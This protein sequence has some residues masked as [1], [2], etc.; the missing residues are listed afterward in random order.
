MSQ[1]LETCHNNLN[2]SDPAVHRRLISVVL[3]RLLVGG[4]GSHHGNLREPVRG[5][6]KQSFNKP[7]AANSPRGEELCRA[8][9]SKE[10]KME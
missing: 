7:G 9:L 5:H 10:S 4:R 1:R 6:K 3:V 2:P 8:T